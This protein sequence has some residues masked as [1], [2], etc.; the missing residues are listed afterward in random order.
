MGRV[1]ASRVF[2][3][4]GRDHAS[5]DVV[6]ELLTRFGLV[7]VQWEGA[8]ALT[9]RPTPHAFEALSS[10]L[11]SVQAAVVL[12][13]GDDCAMLRA[14]LCREYE[15]EDEG[16][17]RPQARPN[18]LFEA[19]YAMAVL[20]TSTIFLQLGRLRSF[21][22]FAGMQFVPLDESRECLGALANRLRLAGC[23]V[24]KVDEVQ[25]LSPSVSSSAGLPESPKQMEGSIAL[26]RVLRSIPVAGIGGGV[27]LTFDTTI[28]EKLIVSIRAPQDAV[29]PE[30]FHWPPGA[31]VPKRVSLAS[32]TRT[33]TALETPFRIEGPAGV[34]VL[35][36]WAARP[37]ADRSLVA[38]G[39]FTVR[40]R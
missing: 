4:S 27:E 2:L 5:R 18:V 8:I 28:G 40:E 26:L 37:N 1:K 14:E 25:V 31:P 10:A 36:V 32:A 23:R 3:I 24:G 9:G 13:T 39:T 6:A 16:V 7:V 38:R 17:L 21:S 33:P 22:D 20:P 35:D 12:L 11:H 30:V 15:R 29:E 34:H 19:G